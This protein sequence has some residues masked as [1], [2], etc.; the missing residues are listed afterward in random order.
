MFRIHSLKNKFDEGGPYEKS[1]HEKRRGFP[2]GGR[3]PGGRFRNCA[4]AGGRSAG[5]GVHYHILRR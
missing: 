1:I 2:G 3:H 4:A 5:F